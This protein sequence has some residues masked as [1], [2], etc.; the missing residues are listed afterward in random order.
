MVARER[1]V[2][3][4]GS[5]VGAR[6]HLGAVEGGGFGLGVTLEVV[7][8]SV[9]CS[10]WSS[11]CKNEYLPLWWPTLYLEILIP[12]S[13][14]NSKC[15]GRGGALL[16]PSNSAEGVVCPNSNVPQSARQ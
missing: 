2:P 12:R 16:F 4:E 15:H 9:L 1:N 3:I 6:L 8:A 14:L 13:T 7:L 5:S 10:E 11:A